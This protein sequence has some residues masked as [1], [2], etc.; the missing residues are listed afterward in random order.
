MGFVRAENRQYQK[1][2]SKERFERSIRTVSNV[3]YGVDAS[4]AGSPL[5]CARGMMSHQCGY[6]QREFIII[7]QLWRRWAG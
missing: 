6:D 1:T 2:R 3:G 4:I 7:F 5:D